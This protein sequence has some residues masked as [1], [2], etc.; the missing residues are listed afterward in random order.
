LYATLRTNAEDDRRGR[1]NGVGLGLLGLLGVFALFCLYMSLVRTAVVG[2][3]IFLAV[4]SYAANKKLFVVGAAVFAALAIVT[5]PYW[6]VAFNPELGVVQHGRDVDTMDIGSG[7]PR[8]WLNDITVFAERPID[9]QL[10]G[11]GIGNRR[12]SDGTEQV[13]GHN[14]WLEMLTQTG[15][16]GLLLFATIQLLILKRI[17][18]MTGREMHI[19]LALYVAVNVMM[20]ISNSYAWRIQVSQLYYMV[21]AFIEIPAIQA[22]ASNPPVP[23]TAR[24]TA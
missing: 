20:F 3:L 8:L 10:A 16:V 12:G 5:S 4:Y 13:Y 2:L 17:L 6:L 15:L 23:A 21:L 22:K 1:P 11:A 24:G 7:R 19:F 14:D 18:Q 9:E